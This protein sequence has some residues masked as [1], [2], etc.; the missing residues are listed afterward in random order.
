MRALKKSAIVYLQAMAFKD[1]YIEGAFDDTFT[2][3]LLL[4][5]YTGSHPYA[6]FVTG[7]LSDAVDLYHTNPVLYYVPKQ[8]ALQGFNE[9]FGNELYMI[10]EHVSDGQKR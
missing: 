9:E 6:P 2:E 8:N 7:S 4:D 10:E 5:F 3:S 1:Q